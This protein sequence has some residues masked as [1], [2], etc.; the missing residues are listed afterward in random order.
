[1]LYFAGRLVGTMLHIGIGAPGMRDPRIHAADTSGRS[2]RRLGPTP[3]YVS[4]RPDSHHARSIYGSEQPA[5]MDNAVSD[6]VPG[7]G[8]PGD[9]KSQ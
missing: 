3:P 8:T 5:A 4:R 1:M 7:G 2:S 6:T 9:V